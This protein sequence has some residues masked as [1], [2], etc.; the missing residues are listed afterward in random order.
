MTIYHLSEVY[1]KILAY[2]SFYYSI[3]IL[4]ICL[5]PSRLNFILFGDIFIRL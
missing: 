2:H 5:D 3:Y 1:Q 4:H